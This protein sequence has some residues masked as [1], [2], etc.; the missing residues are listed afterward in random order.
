MNLQAGID[1]YLSSIPEPKRSDMQIVHEIA[2]RADGGTR[3]W[4][5]DGKDA[6]DKTVSNPTIGYGSYTI[7][8][9]NGTTR[10]FFR[11]GLSANSTGISVHIMGIKDKTYLQETYGKEIG[12]ATLTGYCIKF[13]KLKDINIDVLEAAIRYRLEMQGE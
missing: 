2:Q 7:K 11:V 12:K 3:L 10:E 5:F 1:E 9:A 6:T 8:Y 13:K 4:L